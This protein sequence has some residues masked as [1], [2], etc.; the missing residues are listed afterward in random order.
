MQ[1]AA[2]ASVLDSLRASDDYN[3]V[4]TTRPRGSIP[5]GLWNCSYVIFVDE[6]PPAGSAAGRVPGTDKLLRK[7]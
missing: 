6:P 2:K 3:I 7:R 4:L 5:T 1:P